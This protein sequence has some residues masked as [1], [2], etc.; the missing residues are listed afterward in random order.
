MSGN[1]YIEYTL[2]CEGIYGLA[3]VSCTDLQ[4]WVFIRAFLW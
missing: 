1:Y 4:Q 2:L 3:S